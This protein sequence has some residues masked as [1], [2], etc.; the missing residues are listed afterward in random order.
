MDVVTGM[1]VPYRMET[2]VAH[3]STTDLSMSHVCHELTARVCLH[4]ECSAWLSAPLQRRQ[5]ET[6]LTLRWISLGGLVPLYV[7]RWLPDGISES[8][9]FVPA[10]L[11]CQIGPN[12]LSLFEPGREWAMHP[13]VPKAARAQSAEFMCASPPDGRAS[14]RVNYPSVIPPPLSEGFR[15]FLR[16]ICPFSSSF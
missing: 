5:T 10:P 12:P 3:G 16:Y 8:D 6:A 4:W 1:S 9:A 15:S 2:R 7:L 11:N 14:P 13:E